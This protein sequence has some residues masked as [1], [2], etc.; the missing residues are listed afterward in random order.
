MAAVRGVRGKPI[1][2]ES[3]LALLHEFVS[4]GGR[5]RAFVL[6]GGPGIG[7]SNLWEA[8]IE[9]ARERGVRVLSTRASGAEAQLSFAGLSDL[10]D[11]VDL[12]ALGDMPAPQRR[13]LEVALLRAESGEG[14]PEPRA[15]ALGLL[16][17]LRSL[18]ARGPLLIAIDDSSG[19]ILLP[20]TLSSLQRAD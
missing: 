4:G 1:G 11:E 15:I 14:S 10:L 3:E 8:A 19:S 18:A 9:A 16:N 2:R 17:A 20:P 6:V 5:S 7:K 13:A 12:G